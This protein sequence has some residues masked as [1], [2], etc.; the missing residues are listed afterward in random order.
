[1]SIVSGDEEVLLDE[2]IEVT[3]HI[4]DYLTR[5]SGLAAGDLSPATSP[6]RLC[7]YKVRVQGHEH[8]CPTC[9]ENHLAESMLI[10]AGAS[11]RT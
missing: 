6:H 8:L 7:P 5:F 11:V 3:E 1:V 10:P 2:Y 4:V 9:C